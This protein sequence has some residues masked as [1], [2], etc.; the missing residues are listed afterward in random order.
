LLERARDEATEASVAVWAARRE[1]AAGRPAGAL[2]WLLA[3]PVDS[4]GGAAGWALRADLAGLLTAAGRPEVATTRWA[5]LLGEAQLPVGLR[6]TWLP[7][8]IEAATTAGETVAAERWRGEL[9][10]LPP[11]N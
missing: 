9:A 8:A 4:A 5:A 7:R 6:R 11:G 10:G 2:P 1:L 3:A